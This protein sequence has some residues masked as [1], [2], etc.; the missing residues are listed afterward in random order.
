MDVGDYRADEKRGRKEREPGCDYLM[1]ARVA[2]FHAEGRQDEDDD[3]H[4]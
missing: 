3:A 4:E 2:D 1:R